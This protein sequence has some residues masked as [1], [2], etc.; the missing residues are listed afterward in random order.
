MDS[1]LSEV[2]PLNE[3]PGNSTQ[4]SIRTHKRNCSLK[5][6]SDG[7]QVSDESMNAF[8][9][10][11]VIGINSDRDDS[12]DSKVKTLILDSPKG[13]YTRRKGQILPKC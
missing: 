1:P 9:G 2:I 12:N 5:D 3:F 4:G 7:F 6:I 13:G 10:N 8:P 11:S